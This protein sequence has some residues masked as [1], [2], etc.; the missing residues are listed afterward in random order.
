[1]VGPLR[2]S[3]LSHCGLEE[4]TV[5]LGTVEPS[6][7]PPRVCELGNQVTWSQSVRERGRPTCRHGLRMPAAVL[8]QPLG[9][10]PGAWPQFPVPWKSVGAAALPRVWPTPALP[11]TWTGLGP[12]CVRAPGSLVASLRGIPPWVRDPLKVQAHLPGQCSDSFSVPQAPHWVGGNTPPPVRQALAWPE[13]QPVHRDSQ[14]G[15]R[16]LVCGS[17]QLLSTLCS[18]Q[19][20][21]TRVWSVC[22]AVWRTS[23]WGVVCVQTSPATLGLRAPSLGAFPT[24]GGGWGVSR[25]GPRAALVRVLASPLGPHELAGL[26]LRV[27]GP[28]GLMARVGQSGAG[29]GKVRPPREVQRLQFWG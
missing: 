20:M 1:M 10:P 24:R 25:G 13:K 16:V 8:D 12:G 5:W 26:I 19:G 28:Q 6:G 2:C 9:W 11:C 21:H 27:A 15:C 29:G 3:R 4:P 17:R 18:E 14:G 23:S 22:A 7:P